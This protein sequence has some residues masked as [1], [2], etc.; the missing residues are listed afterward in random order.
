MTFEIVIFR[1]RFIDLHSYDP[2]RTAPLAFAGT[3]QCSE[4][5][6]KIDSHALLVMGIWIISLRFRH[7]NFQIVSW[8]DHSAVSS[9]VEMTDEGN[10]VAR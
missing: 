1:F 10:Q 3:L 9:D 7:H 6:A 8:Y 2:A 4:T 5:H